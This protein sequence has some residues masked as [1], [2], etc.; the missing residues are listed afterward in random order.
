MS[1]EDGEIEEGEQFNRAVIE[2]PRAKFRVCSI[3]RL[4]ICSY[5]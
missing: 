1:N 5:I 4:F 2:S 3:F